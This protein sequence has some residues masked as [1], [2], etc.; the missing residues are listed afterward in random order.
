MKKTAKHFV[1][2]NVLMI[3]KTVNIAI[4]KVTTNKMCK[5]LT[6]VK[7]NDINYLKEV[8]MRWKDGKY[9]TTNGKQIR[10]III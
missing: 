8:D 7:N 4:N 6:K 9:S 3:I 10:Q 5:I 1:P 2:R